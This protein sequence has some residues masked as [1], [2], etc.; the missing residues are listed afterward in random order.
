MVKPKK[1]VRGRPMPTRSDCSPRR[2]QP[3]APRAGG[4][5]PA[6]DTPAGGRPDQG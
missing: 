6:G 5:V 1:T 3:S 4:V 2:A